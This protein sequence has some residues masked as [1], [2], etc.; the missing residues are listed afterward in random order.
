MVSATKA[1][2]CRHPDLFTVCSH[3]L[4]SYIVDQFFMAGKKGAQLELLIFEKCIS[5]NMLVRVFI[6]LIGRAYEPSFGV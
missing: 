4:G 1:Q 5:L 2:L 3:H 6:A